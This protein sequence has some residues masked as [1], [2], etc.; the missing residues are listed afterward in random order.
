L[1]FN[2][3]R[4]VVVSFFNNINSID[5]KRSSTILFFRDSVYDIYDQSYFL[6]CC[7]GE[8]SRRFDFFHP[9]F[10]YSSVSYTT[11]RALSNCI[12]RSSIAW[13]TIFRS[14]LAHVSAQK[15]YFEL[16][17]IWVYHWIELVELY[18]TQMNMWILDEKSR[19]CG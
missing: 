3:A 12:V 8:C 14:F 10:T 5:I 16:S 6:S 13:N 11:R 9:I 15:L 19:I 17:K 2:K 18:K 1:K 4:D 7:V